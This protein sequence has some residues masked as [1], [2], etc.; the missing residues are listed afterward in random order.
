SLWADLASDDAGAAYRAIGLLSTVPA[1]SVA[2]LRERLR[3]ALVDERQI[4]RLIAELESD[5]FAA[6]EQASHDLEQMGDLAEPALRQVLTQKPALEVRRRVERLLEK[7][8]MGLLSGERLRAWRAVET[9]EAIGTP[10]A[11]RAL[12]TL[13]RGVEGARLTKEARAA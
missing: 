13:A 3:P 11:R 12:E 5:R 10:E 6:R 4:A 7:V 9:L 2:Y 1:P 8:E